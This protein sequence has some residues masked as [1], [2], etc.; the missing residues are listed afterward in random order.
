MAVTVI[1]GEE[2]TDRTTLGR[3][4]YL[5]VIMRKEQHEKCSARSLPV[6]ATREKRKVQV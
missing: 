5:Y 2:S 4:G 6:Q 1:P 3:D